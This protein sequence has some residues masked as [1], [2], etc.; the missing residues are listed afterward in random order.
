M[1]GISRRCTTSAFTVPASRVGSEPAADPEGRPRQFA[2]RRCPECVVSANQWRFAPAHFASHS[3]SL[4]LSA[5]S[6][7]IAVRGEGGR[8]SC[9]LF[10]FGA[11]KQHSGA[12]EHRAA[13]PAAA[14]G[15]LAPSDLDLIKHLESKAAKAEQVSAHPLREPSCCLVGEVIGHVFPEVEPVF[16]RLRLSSSL[17]PYPPRRRSA[18]RRRLQGRRSTQPC[19]SSSENGPRRGK[20]SAGG[21]PARL[22]AAHICFTLTRGL[23][24]RTLLSRVVGW[25]AGQR[26]TQRRCR[27][28][29]RGNATGSG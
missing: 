26:S 27:R 9:F 6:R 17:S 21:A 14:H 2:A 20:R 15:D 3:V 23:M 19:P 25:N 24:S 1:G 10:A 12:R 7:E 18:R 13:S 22:R 28:R 11:G 16:S 4:L 29:R 5:F 8:V